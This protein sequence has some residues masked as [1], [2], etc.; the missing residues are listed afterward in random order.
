MP[1]E[2]G[3]FVEPLQQ[4]LPE[5]ERRVAQEELRLCRELLSDHRRAVVE[6]VLRDDLVHEAERLRFLRLA[7]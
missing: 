2:L 1:P 5:R 4:A 3:A 6:G 7:G